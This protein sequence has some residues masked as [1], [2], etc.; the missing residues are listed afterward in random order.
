MPAAPSVAAASAG[1]ANSPTVAVCCESDEW[2]RWLVS[3]E[4]LLWWAKGSQTPPLL[5]NSP[6]PGDNGI[7]GAIPGSTVLIAGED[8]DEATR[9]GARFGVVYWLDSAQLHGFDGRLFF[10]G[11]QTHEAVVSSLRPDGTDLGLFRPFF[12]ANSFQIGGAVFPGPFS[13]RVTGTGISSGSYSANLSSYLW[14]A[15]AN[16]RDCLYLRADGD[17]MFRADLLG[18]FRYVQLDENLTMTEDFVRRSRS[19]NFPDEIIGTRVRVIDQF[20]TT[21]DF[22][23][24]QIGTA[25]TYSRANWSVDLRGTVALGVTHQSLTIAGG[26]ARGPLIDGSTFAAVGGLLALPNANIGQYSRDVFSVVPEIGVTLGYQ[27]TSRWRATLGYN[28]LYWSNVIR[29]GDQID[30]TIDVTR[31]PRFL[32]PNS[33]VQPVFP[34]RPIALLA[35]TDFWAQGISF[36]AEYRW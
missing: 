2:P 12:A 24:G 11:R 20:A 9:Q 7:N 1:A 30:T 25:M 6:P 29:P 5:T 10:L 8:L 35:N 32:P 27:I 23:G 31:I 26:Q 15:E 13:E 22:Y 14:G 36:G 33:N 3:A 21:D 17:R 34:P 16:Y 28:F 4:Y 19:V 18:G